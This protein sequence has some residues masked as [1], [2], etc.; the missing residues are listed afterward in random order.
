ML[1]TH[2]MFFGLVDHEVAPGPSADDD[3]AAAW[4]Y[5]RDAM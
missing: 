4:A 1:D 2:Q 5:V 3:P